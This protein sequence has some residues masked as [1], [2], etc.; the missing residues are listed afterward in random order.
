MTTYNFVHKFNRNN[1]MDNEGNRDEKKNNLFHY[2]QICTFSN[3]KNNKY[4]LRRFSINNENDIV[5]SAD[6]GLSKQQYKKFLSVKKQNEYKCISA[7]DCDM[8]DKPNLSDIL[9]AKSDMISNNNM[10]YGYATF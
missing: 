2:Y 6:F 10:Y 9:I 3:P 5:K 4:H 7:Y 8:I 1:A